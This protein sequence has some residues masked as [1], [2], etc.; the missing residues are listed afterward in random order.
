M[1]KLY[2][3]DTDRHQVSDSHDIVVWENYGSWYAGIGNH[4]FSALREYTSQPFASEAQ[5]RTEANRYWGQ[6]REGGVEAFS[7]TASL[8]RVD[9]LAGMHER[10]AEV[11]RD[12]P[13]KHRRV[14]SS[15]AHLLQN[16]TGGI[17]SGNLW[18]AAREYAQVG[19][20]ELE[21]KSRRDNHRAMGSCAAS[22]CSACSRSVA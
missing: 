10:Q 12:I 18:T 14:V 6:Y 21:R 3:G 20:Y 22:G 5:A 9:D 7:R 1:T 4:G 17:L 19:P 15:R 2:L 16:L 11:L 13:R 8:H